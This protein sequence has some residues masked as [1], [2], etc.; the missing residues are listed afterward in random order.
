M[1]RPIRHYSSLFME[2]AHC[3]SLSSTLDSVFASLGCCKAIP[4]AEW[5]KQQKY[6]FS[7]FWRLKGR[8]IRRL[9]CLFFP[10]APLLDPEMAAFLVFS[11]G[12][13]FV[14]AHPCCFSVYLC[15]D[16]LLGYLPGW[17]WAHPNGPILT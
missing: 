8:C 11:L 15:P 17:L 4:Q 1:K 10:K 7:Q 16:F 5:H 6:I 2:G 9:V 13:S 14:H 3:S 12:L